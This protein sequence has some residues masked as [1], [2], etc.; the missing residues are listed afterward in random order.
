[1]LETIVG[2][3]A[4]VFTTISYVPQV[5]KTWATGETGDLS[6]KMLVLL[7]TGLGL[8]TVYGLL[9]KDWVIFAANSMSLTLVLAVLSFKL[10][11]SSR[12]KP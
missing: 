2:S 10:R 12:S 4:A 1:M 6:L 8:W 5:R 11:A 7:A 9:Q 3:A